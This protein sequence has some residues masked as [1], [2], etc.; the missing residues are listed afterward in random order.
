MK[1]FGK[2]IW[3]SRKQET[4]RSEREAIALKNSI[5]KTLHPLK[6][7]I[8]TRREIAHDLISA[9]KADQ[10]RKWGVSFDAGLAKLNFFYGFNI[11]KMINKKLKNGGTILEIGCGSGRAAAEL[12]PQLN[13][14]IKIIATGVTALSEWKQRQN[15][16]LQFMTAHTPQIPQKIPVKSVD[17]I[18]SNLGPLNVFHPYGFIEKLAPILKN[19]GHLVFTTEFRVETVPKGFKLI[20]K[21]SKIIPTQNPLKEETTL[22][23]YVLK[24]L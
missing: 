9:R 13:E 12:L 7:N 20:K 8:F 21:S 15:S 18:H 6:G 11:V 1:I 2:T 10:A 22:R 14:N 5:K 23:T 24:K 16:R 17:F 4:T 3:F 19:G